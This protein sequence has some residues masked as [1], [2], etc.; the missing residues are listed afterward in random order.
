MSLYINLVLFI[1]N[2]EKN[3][4]RKELEDFFYFEW[5]SSLQIQILI[6]FFWIF[7]YF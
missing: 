4:S 1:N 2:I 6:T 7:Y 5:F 3:N